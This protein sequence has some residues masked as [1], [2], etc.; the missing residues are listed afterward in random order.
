MEKMHKICGWSGDEYKFR[1]QYWLGQTEKVSTG[2]GS[3]DQKLDSKYPKHWFKNL[4]ANMVPKIMCR[5]PGSC[6]KSSIGIEIRKHAKK[7]FLLVMPKYGG[8]Q[9]FSRESF[10]KVGQK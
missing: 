3:L 7:I 4:K 5:K 9:N 2:V 8:K 1:L 6:C 10:P